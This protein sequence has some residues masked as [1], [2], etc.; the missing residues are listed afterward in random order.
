MKRQPDDWGSGLGSDPDRIE[1]SAA[2]KKG[3][4]NALVYFFR[5][6]LPDESMDRIGAPIN[7]KA[8]LVTFKKLTAKGFTHDDIRDMIMAFVKDIT[9]RPLPPHVA[10]WRGF[11]ANVDKYAKGIRK[12]ESDQ[13]PSVPT[14]DKRLLNE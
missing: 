7:A 3:S 9:R 5:D 12:D 11:I 4:A 2:P 14:V 1:E 10:P 6:N 13:E 8:L